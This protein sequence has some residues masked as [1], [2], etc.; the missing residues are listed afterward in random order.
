ML[1]LHYL[2]I[3]L[4]ILL[5]HA[6][7]LYIFILLL[8]LFCSLHTGCSVI[9]ST[10]ASVLYSMCVWACKNMS[11]GDSSRCKTKTSGV[12][13][14]RPWFLNAFL[15][16]SSGWEVFWVWFSGALQW[17]HTP[18][19]P[20]HWQRGDNLYSQPSRNMVAVW[21]WWVFCLCM[22]LRCKQIITWLRVQCEVN[23][24]KPHNS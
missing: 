10:F 21:E 24:I 4:T 7:L 20:H 13:I 6:F 14:L 15:D 18:Q 3:I 12:Q 17:G 23:I 2:Y 9:W 5:L 22:R 11:K 19:Q 1:R 8:L 16:P